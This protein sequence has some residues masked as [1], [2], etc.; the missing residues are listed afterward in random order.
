M[1]K[2]AAF[3]VVSAAVLAAASGCG[4]ESETSGAG[5][6][7]AEGL[8]VR[9]TA[10]T[11]APGEERYLCWTAKVPADFTVTA[12]D[13]ELPEGIHH[14][15][16]TVVDGALTTPA[17]FDCEDAGMAGGIPRFL[18][19]GGPS[20]PGVRFPDGTGMRLAA[21]STV[22]LQLHILNASATARAYAP[23]TVRLEGSSATDLEPVGIV[24]VNDSSLVIPPKSSGTVAGTACTPPE[25][26]EN[27]FM[28]WPHMHLLGRH[29][30]VAVA[31]E[32]VVD[33]AWDFEEQ[34][35]QPVAASVAPPAT[36]DLRCT[37]DNP[38][39]A[40]VGF[41]FSTKDEMCSAFVYHYPATQGLVLC[42]DDE[43]GGPPPGGP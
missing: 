2:H 37:Y 9:S 31:G 35:L 16:V 26:L 30:E 12:V 32:T 4:A 41:G 39:E 28:I 40:A 29:I 20:T 17:P 33:V 14:Y 19:V 10:V 7:P 1:G 15:Q 34:P 27:V 8:V 38:G 21:G 3:S 6:A 5:T 24:L 23:V 36:I 42:G 43:V 22:V 13:R 25:P 18:G 11:L